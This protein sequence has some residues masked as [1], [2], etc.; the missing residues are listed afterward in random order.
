MLLLWCFLPFFLLANSF[1]LVRWRD[2]SKKI[3]EKKLVFYGVIAFI[4]GPFLIYFSILVYDFS[5]HSFFEGYRLSIIAVYLFQPYLLIANLLIYTFLVHQNRE[6]LLTFAIVIAVISLIFLSFIQTLPIVL[7]P[8][9]YDL[10]LVIVLII[11]ILKADFKVNCE[12]FRVS[13]NRISKF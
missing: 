8:F 5:D 9:F 12:W 4:L 13:N 1:Y 2:I 3:L 11:F 7:Y 10:V 6:L